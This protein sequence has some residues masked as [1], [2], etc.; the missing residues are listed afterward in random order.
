MRIGILREGKQPPDKRVPFSPQQCKQL[1]D[2]YPELEISVQPSPIR[3][4]KDSEYKELDIPLQEDLS[5][6]DVLMG[7]KEVP[8]AE[9]IPGKTYF[10]FSHTIK[11]QPYNRKLLQEIVR[12]NI[13]L[14]DYE[15]LTGK[16][17]LRIIGFGR[18][19]GL[20]GAFNGLLTYGKRHKLF[21][22][23]PAHMCEDMAEMFEELKAVSIPPIRMVVTGGGRVA[24]GAMEL[25]NAVG[26]PKVSVEEYLQLEQTDTPVYVQ[27]NP[28]DYNVHR[29]GAT[30]DLE[31]FF[32]KPHA[33]NGTFKRFVSKTD[34]LVAAAYWDPEAPVLFKTEDMNA[35]DF[36]INVIADVTCDI[37]GSIPSTKRART[38]ADPFYDYNPQT[39]KLEEAFSSEKNI[40]VMAIDNLPCEL[41]KDAS[42][43]FGKNLSEKVIPFLIGDDPDQIIGRASITQNGALTAKFSYLTDYLLGKS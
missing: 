9:L 20:V 32:E 13:R 43:D 17:G 4:F 25:F 15:V 12:K 34:L 8:V 11:K 3:C 41:P 6:C 39:G 14:V 29:S 10:F 30:F 36:K 1:L 5:D 35:P 22:L 23:K 31:Y 2:Q 16:D 18:F 28:E 33:Y 7:V 42:I 19:A 40:S 21:D 37:E 24:N 26:I 27:L 38:I